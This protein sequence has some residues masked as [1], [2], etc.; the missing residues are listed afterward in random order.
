MVFTDLDKHTASTICTLAMLVGNIEK[1]EAQL[2]SVAQQMGVPK[3]DTLNLL[4]ECDDLDLIRL[5][6]EMQKREFLNDCFS[7][8]SGSKN[9][10]SEEIKFYNTV[11]QNLGMRAN[12]LN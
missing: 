4:S 11:A 7:F 1:H 8:L 12:S 6:N 2:V 5:E 9:A 3:E 10:P